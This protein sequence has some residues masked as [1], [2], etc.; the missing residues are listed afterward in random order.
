MYLVM[1]LTSLHIHIILSY[2]HVVTNLMLTV[3]NCLPTQTHS[4]SCSLTRFHRSA[5]P[6]HAGSGSGSSTS[7]LALSSSSSPKHPSGCSTLPRNL[8]TNKLARPPSAPASSIN[9]TTDPN[10]GMHI[11]CLS[12]DPN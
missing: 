3:L 7:P 8:K 12:I 5:T 6:T 9:S 1:N 4:C 10:Q 11:K 2:K